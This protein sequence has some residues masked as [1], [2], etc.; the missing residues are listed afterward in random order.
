ME[1]G[2]W[3]ITSADARYLSHGT[4]HTCI[5]EILATGLKPGSMTCPSG[6]KGIHLSAV[7]PHGRY[8]PPA[9]PSVKVYPYN[10]DLVIVV[11]VEAVASDV[12]FSLS[13]GDVVVTRQPIE[14]HAFVEAYVPQPGLQY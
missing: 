10:S 14:V 1:M 6:R 4:S 8:P 3:A 9:D 2:R 12:M 5:A 7:S 13:N 11:D